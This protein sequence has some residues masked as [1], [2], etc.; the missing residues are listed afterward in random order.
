MVQDHL[1]I[2]N[3]IVEEIF[4]TLLLLLYIIFG[5]YAIEIS[6]EMIEFS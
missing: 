3:K 2:A 4:S 1:K 5:T 6:S